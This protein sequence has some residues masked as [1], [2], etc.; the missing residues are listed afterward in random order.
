MA[1]IT[2]IFLLAAALCLGASKERAWQDGKVLNPTHNPYF[3]VSENKNNPAGAS[4][5]SQ[6]SDAGYEASVNS[7]TGPV[8]VRDSYVIESEETVYLVERIRLKNAPEGRVFVAMPVKIAVEKK[9]LRLL[10]DQGKEH[11]LSI[12]KQ[13]EKPSDK[14]PVLAG[15]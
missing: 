8:F 7:P 12:V 4:A 11:T 15:R 13:F 5:R 6:S 2:S 10:D 1:R 9:K 3:S 14:G